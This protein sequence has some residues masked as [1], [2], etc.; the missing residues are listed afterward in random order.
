MAIDCLK[1]ILIVKDTTDATEPS[2][3]SVSVATVACSAVIALSRWA[4]VSR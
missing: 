3:L 4:H 2:M 1:A